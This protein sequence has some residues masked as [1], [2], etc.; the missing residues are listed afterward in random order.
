MS[1]EI[2]QCEAEKM[3]S[4][5]GLHTQVDIDQYFLNE[6]WQ[7][8]KQESAEQEAYMEVMN[9]NEPLSLEEIQE[10]DYSGYEIYKRNVRSQM[11]D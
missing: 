6:A 2:Y 1:I 8:V 10:G 9:E 11:I 4:L 3:K 5:M 7:H